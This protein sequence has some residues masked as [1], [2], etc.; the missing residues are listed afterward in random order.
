[1]TKAKVSGGFQYTA[2]GNPTSRI[3]C[4]APLSSYSKNGYLWISVCLWI[5]V[6]IL[7]FLEKYLALRKQSQF[8]V[9]FNQVGTTFESMRLY[10]LACKTHL[11]TRLQVINA[12]RDKL[13]DPT[14]ASIIEVCAVLSIIYCTGTSQSKRTLPFKLIEQTDLQISQQH[15][16][17]LHQTGHFTIGKEKKENLFLCS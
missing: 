4:S 16:F 2:G 11:K 10:A 12:F 7:I 8:S 9:P 6:H 5:Y 13:S 17:Y 15:W 14:S 3:P 1:M